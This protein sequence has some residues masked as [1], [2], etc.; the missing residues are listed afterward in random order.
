MPIAITDD[1]TKLHYEEAGSGEPLIFAHEMTGDSRIWEPQMRY[2]SRLYRCIS[3]DARGYTPSDIPD[4]PGAYSQH[5]AADDIAA[6]MRHLKLDSAAVVGL[7]MG[8]YTALHFGIRHPHM[9][10]ALVVAGCGHGSAREVAEIW[11]AQA[12]QMGERLE[13][14]GMETIAASYANSAYRVQFRDKDPRGWAEWAQRLAEHSAAGLARSVREVQGKRPSV[15]DLET[16][17]AAMQVPVLL[18]VGD[19]DEPTLEMNLY[20]KRTLPMSGLEIFSKTGHAVNSEEPAR[21]NASV[22]HFLNRVAL[23]R[24]GARS[25]EAHHTEV[26]LPDDEAKQ[27]GSV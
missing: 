19:E 25:V 2:F 8:A 23:G 24:W 26:W 6:L 11:P 10:R 13:S 27:G 7:S 14:E 4:E 9:A 20:M 21:F 22:E 16:D 17:L 3:Y 15:L 1:G 5:R 12:R 18:V